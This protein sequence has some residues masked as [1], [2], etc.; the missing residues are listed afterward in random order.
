M[1]TRAPLLPAVA[2]PGRETLGNAL[3]GQHSTCPCKT[4]GIKLVKD[5]NDSKLCDL[6]KARSLLALLRA[7]AGLS[8]GRCPQQ[9]GFNGDSVCVTILQ[10]WQ[11]AVF[12][13]RKAFPKTGQSRRE[14]WQCDILNIASCRVWAG[15]PITPS[16]HPMQGK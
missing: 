11:P 7:G 2:S 15:L 5:V 14:R 1:G 12:K 8:P 16:W 3:S 10:S 13:E 9:R 4:G 6:G